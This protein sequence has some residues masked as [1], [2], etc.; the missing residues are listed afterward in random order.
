MKDNR[1]VIG[2]LAIIATFVVGVVLNLLQTVLIPLVVAAFLSYLFKPLVTFLE[3]RRVPTFIS[4]ILVFVT[5][6]AVLFG[7][8]AVIYASAVSF[9]EEAPKYQSRVNEI[10][11][12]LNTEF[13]ALTERYNLPVEDF[14]WRSVVNV[15]MLTG[16]LGTGLGSTVS[17]VGNIVLVLL[18]MAF[19]LGATGDFA[20]KVRVSFRERYSAT[21]GTVVA[22][23]D[24]QV[25]Q[26]LLA[27]TLISLASGILTT[28]T[29]LLFGVEF[30]IFWG[31]LTFILNYIPNFGSIISEIF[32]FLM[33]L[34]QF[35]TIVTPLIILAILIGTD[36]IIG[37]VVEPKVMAFSMDLSP[38]VVLV[39]LIFWGWLWGIPG[40]ILAVP[41]TVVLKIIFEN[42]EPLEP[43]ARLMGGPVRKEETP[44]LAAG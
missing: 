1:V 6:G 32:P 27:K 10:A 31:F 26:Y 18:Y 28:V 3:R 30:A 12:S 44:K 16:M 29:L 7:I 37:N 24:E 4:L 25:R 14:D 17:F 2:L 8:S 15:S 11:T 40:M 23:I 33:A 9:V 36:T 19:I 39:A 41:M 13:T 35:D 22:R 20:E 43:L 42:V 38:L 5:I 21:I 34:L